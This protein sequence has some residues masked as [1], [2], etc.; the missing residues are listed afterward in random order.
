M[1]KPTFQD[2]EDLGELAVVSTTASPPGQEVVVHDPLDQVAEKIVDRAAFTEAQLR[3]RE[4][5]AQLMDSV[6]RSQAEAPRSKQ[7]T[8]GMSQLG[9]CRE[10]IR[11]TVA[12]D[13]H[14]EQTELKWAAYVGTA[15]GDLIERDLAAMFPD[16]VVTQER[17]SVRMP[18]SNIVVTGSSDLLL[19]EEAIVDLKTRDGLAEVRREGPPPKEMVQISGYLVGAVQMGL[20]G[21]EAIGILHYLDRSGSDKGFHSWSVDFETAME[22]LEIADSRLKDVESALATGRR[23]PRDMP[24][25]WCFHTQC[26]FY[27]ACWEG[28]VPSN[29]IT[30]P[31]QIEAVA[32]YKAAADEAKA[33]E[34]NKKAK[35]DAARGISGATPFHT[36]QWRSREGKHGDLIET[37][38]VRE[39]K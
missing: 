12:G 33:A 16:F 8:L 1:T 11:A 4:L 27:K 30:D 6:R 13:E 15:V 25:S 34:S 37:I 18:T 21:P 5:S 3:G 39:R 19:G 14:D 38:D 2:P 20:I 10:Y 32:A 24:E 23:A 36:I 22:F 17:I 9:G 7:R 31:R 29:E 35:R 26:P 28:Y